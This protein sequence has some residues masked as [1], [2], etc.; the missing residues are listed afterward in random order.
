MTG[1]R[2]ITLT[3]AAHLTGRPASTLRRWI[4]EG[5]LTRHGTPRAIRLDYS[6][7]RDVDPTNP[8]RKKCP[9]RRTAA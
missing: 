2:L 6:E 8:R 5:R 4:M 9:P 3:D 7:L 1:P